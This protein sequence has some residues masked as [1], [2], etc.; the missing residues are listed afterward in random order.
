M[1]VNLDAVID[2]WPALYHVTYAVN[3]PLIRRRRQLQPAADLFVEAGMPELVSRRRTADVSLRIDGHEVVVRN[4]RPLRPEMVE[5]ESGTFTDYIG[6]LNSRI[7]FWPGTDTGLADDGVRMFQ[8]SGAESSIMIR[9]DS[10]S[11]I[12]ANGS[13]AIDL[14]GCN[15][16]AGWIEGGR[17]SRRGLHV[18]EPLAS[19]SRPAL[20]VAEITFRETVVLPCDTRYADRADGP[21]RGLFP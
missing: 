17:K 18:F 6:C 3:L 14:S 16:G 5:I 2:A 11:L 15:A 8:R 13:G 19:F 7:F 10:R 21:W 9:I 4:Q 20:G 1:T 12:D